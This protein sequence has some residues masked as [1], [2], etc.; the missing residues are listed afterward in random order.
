MV[1]ASLPKKKSLGKRGNEMMNKVSIIIVSYNEKA[2]LQRALESC[3]RQTWSNIEI[4]IGDDGSSDGSV[5]IIKTFCHVHSNVQA[6]Y[7][8][9]DR[10]D[11]VRNIIPSIRVSN[12]LKK[13]FEIA[14][15]DYLVVLSADDYFI[16][17]AKIEKAVRFLSENPKFCAYIT[18]FKYVGAV[19]GDNYPRR[20][21]KVLYWSGD[22]LHISCFVFRR[23]QRLLDRF[24][25]DTGLMYSLLLNGKWK[26]KHELSF[27]YYRR[28][29][30]ITSITKQ[31]ELNTIEV[32]LY[33][34]CLN[35]KARYRHA[36]R[37]RFSRPALELFLHRDI[38]KEP[39]Y[40]KYLDNSIQFNHNLLGQ[41]ADYDKSSV[42]Q[43]AR[44]VAIIVFMQIDDVLFKIL[45]IIL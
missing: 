14:S 24:C 7:F 42:L 12:L 18:G 6:R 11:D 27:A 45:R 4:I 44:I 28:E 19:E 13:G 30:S 16:D 41:I 1:S 23:P 39:A 26:F 21:S 36:T 22:Y 15:G 9:M 32:M 29:D 33:Q 25:D 5:D 10:P 37:A 2:Y 35:S 38:L 43:K 20:S 8:V 34:D 31:S 40:R 17:E 3:I